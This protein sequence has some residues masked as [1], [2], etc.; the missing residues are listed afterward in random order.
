VKVGSFD[1]RTAARL[2]LVGWAASLGWLARREFSTD[3]ATIRL[4]PEAHFYAVKAGRYQIGYASITVDTVLTGFRLSEVLALDVPTGDSVRRVTRRTDVSL[5]RSLRLIGFDRTVMGGGLFEQ[6]TGQVE[7]DSVLAMAKREGRDQPS[8]R[9]RVRLPGDVV[10]P[11]VL[12]Y[13]LA[14]GKR[15]E[16]GRIVEANVLELATGTVNKVAFTATTDSMFVVADSAIEQR[17][18]K[19]W[20][21]VRYDTVRAFRI[22]HEAIGAPVVSWVDEHGGLV[23]SEAAL[24]I[25]L[26]RS[27]FELVSVNYRQAVAREG[28]ANHRSVTGIES[29][30]E[31]GV[32]PAVGGAGDY[33]VVREPI[34]RFLLPRVSWL[35]GDGQDAAENGRVQTRVAAAVRDS[36][37]SEYLG[38]AG[39]PGQPDSLVARM[40]IEIAGDEVGR[41]RIKSLTK[42]LGRRLR[43]DPSPGAPAVPSQVLA[44]RR[45]GAE[46]AAAT[47]AAMARSLGLDARVVGGILLQAGKGYS[48]SWTEVE[49]DGEWIGAD[50]TFG[51]FPASAQLIRVTV[52]GAGRPIDMVPLIGAARFEPAPAR[53]SAQR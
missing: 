34:E 42:W 17:L 48:H 2:V 6:F 32:V 20:M 13:R 15:L 14:F 23:M 8:Q 30:L 40:A 29:V 10:L 46:G 5:S 16:V 33:R 1:R 49:V 43:I 9:W 11:Q 53:A 28:P 31:A 7:G 26:E 22:E 27:A 24:G 47:L 25:R 21:A 3:E 38:P 19:R 39:Y 45:A 35:A 4:N 41:E 44:E 51:Q 52:G 37:R 18:T 12:P 50:P 36:N